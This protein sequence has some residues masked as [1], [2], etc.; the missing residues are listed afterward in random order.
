MAYSEEEKIEIVKT[1][2]ERIMG[3]ESMRSITK[4]EN[5]PKFSTFLIWISE[6]EQKSKQYE[7]AMKVRS[8]LMFEELLDIADDGTNDYMQKLTDNGFVDVYNSEHVQRS[9]LRVDARKWY[10]SKLNPKKFGDK[11]DAN[12]NH[13]GK[14]QIEQITGM[15]IK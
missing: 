11:I 8:E 10:L 4:D 13:E 5:L 14:I 15:V 6:D 2:C 12:L 9:R 1:V 3:G 7:M